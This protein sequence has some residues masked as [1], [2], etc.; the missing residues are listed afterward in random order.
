MSKKRAET[1]TYVFMGH[2]ERVRS[3][4]THNW[5]NGYSENGDTAS[6][7]FTKTEARAQARSEGKRAVFEVKRR[8]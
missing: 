1:V 5:Y 7:W 3:D 6:P 4:G 2:L 8:V